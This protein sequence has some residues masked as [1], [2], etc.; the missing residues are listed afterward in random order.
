[1]KNTHKREREELGSAERFA[2]LLDRVQSAHYAVMREN[3]EGCVAGRCEQI[4]K[5]NFSMD[6]PKDLSEDLPKD[7]SSLPFTGRNRC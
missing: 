1:M 7:S 4:F 2:Q 5:L 3:L 6:R